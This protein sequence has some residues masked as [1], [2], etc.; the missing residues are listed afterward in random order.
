MKVA[1]VEWYDDWQALYID[2]K[3]VLSNHTVDS[4]DLLYELSKRGLLTVVP[5]KT[6][7]DDV[8]W[9]SDDCGGIDNP[10]ATFDER[11]KAE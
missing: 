2:G 7:E 5:T 9:V 1:L 11:M 10:P 3:L 8:Y 6:W 4:S